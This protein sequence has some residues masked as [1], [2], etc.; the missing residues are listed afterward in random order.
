[1]EREWQLCKKGTNLLLYVAVLNVSQPWQ[2]CHLSLHLSAFEFSS[3]IE[4]G[5]TFKAFSS[6]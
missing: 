6:R 2:L 5:D 1:M 4:K 3:P